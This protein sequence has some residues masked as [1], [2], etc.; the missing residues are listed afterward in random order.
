VNILL[1]VMAALGG[2]AVLG[3]TVLGAITITRGKSGGGG[4]RKAA[5]AKGG[6]RGGRGARGDEDEEFDAAMEKLNREAERGIPPEQRGQAAALER[7][8]ALALRKLR[9][10]EVGRNALASLPFYM[11]IGPSAAGKT[12]LLLGSRLFRPDDYAKGSGPTLNCVWW[13]S[14]QAV[15]LDTA[16]RWSEKRSAPFLKFL[17]LVKNTRKTRPLNGLLLVIPANELVAYA[18]DGKS[19]Q[20]LDALCGELRERV[21]EVIAELEFQVP[22][23]LIVSKCDRLGGFDELFTPLRAQERDRAKVWGFTIPETIGRA[24]DPGEV[25]EN[26]E[27]GLR[28][29]SQQLE[30]YTLKRLTQEWSR[31]DD[32]GGDQVADDQVVRPTAMCGFLPR[33]QDLLA[34]VRE[35][36]DKLLS[37]DIQAP[38]LRGVYF[39]S[40]TQTESNVFDELYDRLLGSGGSFV[41]ERQAYGQGGGKVATDPARRD[42]VPFFVRSLMQS[43]LEGDAGLAYENPDAEVRRVKRLRRYTLGFGAATLALAGVFGALWTRANAQLDELGKAAEAMRNSSLPGA[44]PAGFPRPEELAATLRSVVKGTKTGVADEARVALADT[45]RVLVLSPIFEELRGKVTAERNACQ[46]IRTLGREDAGNHDQAPGAEESGEMLGAAWRRGVPRSGDA[47][48]DREAGVVAAAVDL[49]RTVA[50]EKATWMHVNVGEAAQCCKAKQ[51][52]S[53]VAS[54]DTS[55]QRS[56]PGNV[57]LPAGFIADHPLPSKYTVRAKESFNQGL[58]AAVGATTTENV[59]GC[60]KVVV[61]DKSLRSAYEDKYQA[62]WV[63]FL[64]GLHWQNPDSLTPTE[65]E[66]RLNELVK[67]LGP[68]LEDPSATKDMAARVPGG[69]KVAD[70]I[71][72]ATAVVDAPEITAFKG[73]TRTKIAAAK[74]YL[75][76]LLAAAEVEAKKDEPDAASVSDKASA[77][78]ATAD[79]DLE[80][81]REPFEDI[82]VAPRL[83]RAVGVHHA[84]TARDAWCA[85]RNSDLLRAYPLDPA[86]ATDAV[87]EAVQAW[88]D[89][90]DPPRFAGA[91]SETDA[92]VLTKAK[93]HLDDARAQLGGRLDGALGGKRQLTIGLGDPHPTKLQLYGLAWDEAKLQCKGRCLDASADLSLPVAKIGFQLQDFSGNAVPLR[94]WTGAYA[95]VRLVQAAGEK[96]QLS[97]TT[98]R[99][100]VIALPIKLGEG[101]WGPWTELRSFA[102]DVRHVKASS[103]PAPAPAK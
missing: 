37:G 90:F 89:G 39:T 100:E 67:K 50:A 93:S 47:G 2:V 27:E 99:G 75:S 29:L 8:F 52:G 34:G 68:L 12:Q 103:C 95:F 41:E 31:T 83:R 81:L 57:S 79:K 19:A 1:Y 98:S 54:L 33:F 60:P 59:P 86:S 26:C 43:V 14:K 85:F 5:G 84:Q 44:V 17:S 101:F 3:A 77:F 20:K 18:R 91:L 87:P 9:A 40:A 48:P 70:L 38:M 21:S 63:S 73:L 56:Y 51:G 96:Q 10:S 11:I 61:D 58:T 88:L 22:V 65:F 94:G 62:A 66:L 16:G 35:V 76:D 45:M 55:L 82:N 25:Q 7:D 30:R 46:L 23:Y 42:A 74:K 36:T 78:L 97:A 28:D 49:Y 69:D 32:G 4:A 15:V 102:A 24:G 6:S 80:V 92:Q 71:G 64:S 72:K 13:L 53:A